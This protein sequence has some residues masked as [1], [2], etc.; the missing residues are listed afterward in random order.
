MMKSE[1][2][3]IKSVG[4]D[5]DAKVMEAIAAGKMTGTM[6]QNPWGQAYISMYTLKMLVDGWKYKAGQPEVINSGSFLITTYNIALYED[7][8]K[9]ETFKIMGTWTD[10]FD[11]PANY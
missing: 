2:S 3:E 11:P 8:I 1:Y 7:M 5:T 6:S 4:F 9:N 10:R